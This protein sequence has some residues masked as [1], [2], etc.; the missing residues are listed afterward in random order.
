MH[1]SPTIKIMKYTFAFLSFLLLTCGSYAQAPSQLWIKTNVG[2]T[3]Q[4]ILFDKDSNILVRYLNNFH[5]VSKYKPDGTLLW[6]KKDSTLSAGMVTDGNGSTY[7][8]GTNTVFGKNIGRLCKIDRNGKLLWGFNYSDFSIQVNFTDIAMGTNGSLYISAYEETIPALYAIDTNGKVLHK[9]WEPLSNGL[10]KCRLVR[11]DHSGNI[12]VAATA[13]TSQ[14]FDTKPSPDLLLVK[15]KPDGTVIWRRAVRLDSVSINETTLPDMKIDKQDNIIISQQGDEGA[16]ERYTSFVIKFGADGTR[17][18]VQKFTPIVSQGLIYYWPQATRLAIASTGNVMLAGFQNTSYGSLPNFYM[19]EL[20]GSNGSIVWSQNNSQLSYNTELGDMTLD[21]NDNMYLACKAD[22]TSP[23]GFDGYLA[24]HSA[25]GNRKWN[26]LYPDPSGNPA[27]FD[28][29]LPD[30]KG[31]IYIGGHS[32]DLKG[33]YPF[34]AKYGPAKST[35]LAPAPD[36]PVVAA[37]PNPFT[38]QVSFRLPGNQNNFTID[39]YDIRGRN[40]IHQQCH[41]TGGDIT[42]DMASYPASLYFYQISGNGQYF[43]G[44]LVK[45]E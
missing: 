28:A 29:L 44:K 4:Q 22:L 10:G 11:M 16:N 23:F 19:G 5:G 9:I 34:L 40:I 27:S 18:W 21:H 15:Y 35:G 3:A 31:N 43:T 37:Y 2:G 32:A 36:L 1:R 24:A 38:N 41:P 33:T 12:I 8:C 17:K 45:G 39:I 30:N 13:D 7:L 6:T 26:L 25:N 14:N 20:D 42:L